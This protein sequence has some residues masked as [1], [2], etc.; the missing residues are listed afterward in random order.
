MIMNK[1]EIKTVDD[2]IHSL[3]RS[4]N[5]MLAEIKSDINKPVYQKAIAE[6]KA[7]NKK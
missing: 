5:E 4:K 3:V 1:I 2:L 6:L 7:L